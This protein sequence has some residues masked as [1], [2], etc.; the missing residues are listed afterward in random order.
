[1]ELHDNRHYSFS[2]IVAAAG[3]ST[4]M[5]GTDK[6]FA[7]L[8][9][10]PVLVRTLKVLDSVDSI[11]EIILVIS[12]KNIHRIRDLM[13]KNPLSKLIKVIEGGRTRQESVYAG[14]T[15][16]K[17]DFVAIHDGA[18][19]FVTS[20]LIRSIFKETSEFDAVIP[21][22]PVVDTI[23]RV[24]ARG[25]V[26][27]TI[28]RAGVFQVQTPQ[29][30]RRDTWLKAYEY[31]LKTKNFVTDDAS[32]LEYA[33][34]PVKVVP[35]SRFNIKITVPDDIIIGRIIINKLARNG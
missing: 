19:P 16:A 6:L 13:E 23:K 11:N 34:I 30:I 28:D 10:F 12:E 29:V 25:M 20:N 9:G 3:N 8:E 18:R 27:G 5:D 1:M 35:G 33:G 4:R 2:A 31:I 32:M 24:D 26:T 14:V 17:G 22:I 21:A 7:D 15:A